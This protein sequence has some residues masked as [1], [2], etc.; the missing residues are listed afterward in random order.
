MRLALVVLLLVVA[1]SAGCV[2]KES[3]PDGTATTSS[4]ASTTT[5]TA[6]S[7]TSGTQGP[8]S[9]SGPGAPT[10][11]T[12]ALTADVLNG[13][14]P[15]DVNFTINATGSPTSWRLSF[16]DGAIAN[17]TAIPALANHTYAIGGNFSANLTVH[18]AAGNVTTFLNL[19]I[20]VP[21][22]PAGP[23]APDVTHFAFAD[24]LGCVGDLGA[25]NCISFVG[26]PSASGIDGYWQALDERYWGL[27]F[28]STIMQGGPVGPLLN[29]SDCVFTDAA[30][31]ILGEANNSSNP[32]AGTVP[33]GTAFLFIY[34]YGTPAL[35]MAVD[36]VV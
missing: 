23:G 11:G 26:G 28:T 25:E 19:T 9:G 14:A 6:T 10:L 4:S 1:A 32:C 7:S 16:G 35:E 3:D 36:F 24:S 15:V 22:T 33:A 34:P 5:S 29:D 18:Y 2:S 30:H 13:T 21:D 8:G 17:G 12:I 20:A 31:A 27:A